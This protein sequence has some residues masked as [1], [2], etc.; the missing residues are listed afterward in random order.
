MTCYLQFLF[1]FFSFF[2]SFLCGAFQW[3]RIRDAIEKKGTDFFVFVGFLS[4]R[5]KEEKTEIK[6]S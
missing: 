3:L 4:P 6:N 5:K 2:I 1:L